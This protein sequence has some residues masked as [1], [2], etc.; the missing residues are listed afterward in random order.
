MP[1]LAVLAQEDN[2]SRSRILFLS[3]LGNS[4]KQ[5]LENKSYFVHGRKLIGLQIRI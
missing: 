5:Y 3:S 4:R 2:F 1:G